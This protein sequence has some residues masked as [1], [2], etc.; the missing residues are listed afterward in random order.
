MEISFH[1]RERR[2]RREKTV[3]HMILPSF[4]PLFLC[5]LCVLCDEISLN[6]SLFPLDCLGIA[7]QA[8]FGANAVNFA[9]D[10]I[11]LKM[12][13]SLKPRIYFVKGDFED[14]EAYK[15]L[16]KQ[17]NEADKAHNCGGNKFFYLA[18]APR[19]FAP[20]VDRLGARKS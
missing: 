6:L 5:V 9:H 14:P 18:V 2:E 8:V 17:I 19:F 3:K 11:D 20:I 13:D 12:W 7:R 4:F 15:R 1:R 10:P 16:E